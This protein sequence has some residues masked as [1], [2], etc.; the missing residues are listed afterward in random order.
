MCPWTPSSSP[1]P[2]SSEIAGP[3]S[4]ALAATVELV[5]GSSRASRHEPPADHDRGRR[6]PT[7]RSLDPGE[8]PRSVRP[9][10]AR[11]PGRAP[12]SR[13]RPARAHGLGARLA[14]CPLRAD[15]VPLGGD[16]GH[17]RL[18]PTG[19]LRRPAR[20]L[21]LALAAQPAADPRAAPCHSKLAGSSGTLPFI[22]RLASTAKGR[23]GRPRSAVEPAIS[24]RGS[25]GRRRSS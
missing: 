10:R 16:G 18:G 1:W 17:A 22:D 13:A 6:R 25:G 19:R 8:R 12:G 9:L 23:S 5:S 20:R 11:G 21:R 14:G 7:G 4:S 3:T 2:N 24:P 15:R